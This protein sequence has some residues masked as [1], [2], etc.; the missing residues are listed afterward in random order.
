[1]ETEENF[2]ALSKPV[3]AG[4]LGSSVEGD[5]P[6]SC[7]TFSMDGRGCSAGLVAAPFMEVVDE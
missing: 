4:V 5:K 6:V 7:F 3:E 2:A 1:M